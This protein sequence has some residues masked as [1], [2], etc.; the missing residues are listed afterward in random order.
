MTDSPRLTTDRAADALRSAA[1]PP[2][3]AG[4]RA[5]TLAALEPELSRAR[6]AR[7]RRSL[8]K[9]ASMGC[10]LAALSVGLGLFSTGTKVSAA[11]R[12]LEAFDN[13]EKAPSFRFVTTIN[14]G[15]AGV[16]AMPDSKTFYQDGKMRVESGKSITITD[17]KRVV[18]LDAQAKV[19]RT[20]DSTATHHPPPKALVTA[21]TKRIADAMQGRGKLD[22]A[23]PVVIGGK[24]RTGFRLAAARIGEDLVCDVTIYLNAETNTPLRLVIKATKP[25]TFTSTTDYIGLGEPLD[26]KLFDMT[27]PAGYTTEKLKPLTPERVKELL[28]TKP[29]AAKTVASL[30]E[31]PP[32]DPAAPPLVRALSNAKRVKSYRVEYTLFNGTKP[33][34]V[35]RQLFQGGIN[36]S[37]YDSFTSL[38][39]GQKSLTLSPGTKRAERREFPGGRAGTG[40]NDL[41]VYA[42]IAV[43]ALDAGVKPTPVEAVKI[44]GKLRPGY[45]VVQPA[46][47]NR[48]ALD[49]TFWL[50]E[51]K[52]L[53]LRLLDRQEL[54]STLSTR[55]DYLGLDEKLDA[56]LFEMTTPPGYVEVKL[57]PLAPKV[58]PPKE[59]PPA[60]K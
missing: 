55:T 52:N 6:R 36:R 57:P 58:A 22:P 2:L 60:K 33:I 41:N 50:D 12:L 3:P 28:T 46:A 1:T 19:A 48:R 13:L 20:M 4:L 43:Y 44:A 30:S 18:I 34:L 45:R 9:Y 11:G 53:P 49:M 54:P 25:R 17:G 59:V 27:I 15:G 7:R 26:A 24:L 16:P 5:A 40:V 56:K 31:L 51:A 38:F 8:M 35:I 39:D 21:E 37:E 23:E 42:S 29:A 10:L 14:G 47:G 32:A